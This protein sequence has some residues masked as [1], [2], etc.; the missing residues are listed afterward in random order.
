MSMSVLTL[1][2]K[3]FVV[4]PEREYRT[5]KAKADRTVATGRRSKPSRRAAPQDA[6]DAAEARRRLANPKRIP[7][8]E[9]FQKLGL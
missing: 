7:A 1:N 4:L 9:V 3:R 6:G 5:L 2:G 8:A